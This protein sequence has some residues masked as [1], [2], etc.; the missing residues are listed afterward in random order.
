MSRLSSDTATASEWRCSCGR[1]SGVTRYHGDR[2][3]GVSDVTPDFRVQEREKREDGRERAAEEPDAVDS[4]TD[5]T[6]KTESE[7][8]EEPKTQTGTTDCLRDS[9]GTENQEPSEDTPKSRHI[10]GGA[11]L[12]KVQS[13][14]RDSQLLKREMGGRRGEDRVGEKG[15]GEGSS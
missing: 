9:G 3:A 2:G 14:L 10:P 1:E 5:E 4:Q 7:E 6:T 8:D 11:W 15:V 13:F 12:T